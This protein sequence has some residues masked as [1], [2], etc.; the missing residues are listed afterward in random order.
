M[1]IPLGSEPADGA[2]RAH[3]AVW[4]VGQ[5]GVGVVTVGSVHGPPTALVEAA[6]AGVVGVFWA[7]LI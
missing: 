7:I 5:D 6:V 4:D 3:P 1:C 2:L